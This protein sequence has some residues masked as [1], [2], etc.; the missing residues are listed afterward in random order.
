MERDV[1]GR[2]NIF[3]EAFD[4]LS[5]AIQKEE[6]RSRIRI[7]PYSSLFSGTARFIA[8]GGSLSATQ[9]ATLMV[10]LTDAREYFGTDKEL[11]AALDHLDGLL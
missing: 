10:H 3:G 5:V 7:Y 11:K 2:D 8:L 9:R 4:K 1:A 6:G